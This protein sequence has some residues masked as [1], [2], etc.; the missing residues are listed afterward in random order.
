MAGNWSLMTIMSSERLLQLAIDVTSIDDAQRIAEA[1]YPHFDIV[2]IGTP[3]IVDQGLYALE[4]IKEKC[5]NKQ[6]LADVKIAD[7]GYLEASSAFKRGADI[8]TVLG[9]SDDV[10]IGGVVKAAKESGGLVMADMLH[11]A[12]T[13]QRGRELIERGVD[14]ICLHTAHDLSGRGLDPL[15]ELVQMREAV[16]GTLAVAGGLTI[17]N[18]AEAIEKGAD[19]LVVGGGITNAEDPRRTAKQI[20]QIMA[21][22]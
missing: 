22:V 14:I 4:A 6:Y 21:T 13:P 3:L 10:T 11:V 8:A 9:V 15:R 20:K 7:G 2:E 18:V 17:E 1:V 16:D 19:I 12:N 5:P